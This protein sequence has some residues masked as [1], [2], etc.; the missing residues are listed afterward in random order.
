MKRSLDLI[1]QHKRPD[2]AGGRAAWRKA[3]QAARV[4]V[5]TELATHGPEAAGELIDPLLKRLDAARHAIH[6]QG[7]LTSLAEL[8]P[9]AAYLP[10]AHQSLF[11]SVME[12]ARVQVARSNPQ[13]WNPEGVIL[14]AFLRIGAGEDPGRQL[15][16]L[17]RDLAARGARLFPTAALAV[18]HAALC[19]TAG[20]QRVAT[21]RAAPHQKAAALSAVASHLARV[22]PRPCPV[23]NSIGTDRFT[24]AIQHLALKV[25]SATRPDNETPIKLLHQALATAGWHHAIPVLARLAPEA[26][27]AVRD[28]V[29]VH[30]R[31]SHVSQI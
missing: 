6:S 25:T 23:P 19:D 15:D 14:E 9:T 5:A 20:A 21:L 7:P 17:A 4:A 13:S 24:H 3:D 22:P 1:T 16:S 11:D 18:L 29:M 27:A 2:R 12:G 31:A 30:L 8:L 28:I 26:V 10:S